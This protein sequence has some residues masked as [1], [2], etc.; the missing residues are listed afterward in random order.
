[1]G[2]GLSESQKRLADGKGTRPRRARRGV[3]GIGHVGLI[4]GVV[5]LILGGSGLA[6]ALTRAGATGPAGATGATGGTGATGPQGPA[7]PGAV[8]NESN[9]GP[10]P[11]VSNTSC[12]AEPGADVGFKVSQAG[13]V[14]VTATTTIGVDDEIGGDA[15]VGFYISASPTGCGSEPQYVYIVDQPDGYYYTSISLAQSF[16]VSSP[17]TYT[18]YLTSDW[19]DGTAPTYFFTTT[20]VGVYYPST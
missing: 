20:I 4:L 10:E 15:D 3:L 2:A 14:F 6:V 17:G 8:V 19:V 5:A 13:S 1:M 11:Q 18:F 7:G 16:T 12:A 9:V